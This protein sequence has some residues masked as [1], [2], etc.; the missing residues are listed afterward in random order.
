VPNASRY[1]LVLGLSAH[2]QRDWPV[3]DIRSRRSAC[4]VASHQRST[5]RL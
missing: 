1:R 4:G 2:A 3:V 5:A